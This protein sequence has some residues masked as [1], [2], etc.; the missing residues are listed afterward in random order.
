MKHPGQGI[1][2]RPAGL[3]G[4]LKWQDMES[5]AMAYQEGVQEMSNSEKVT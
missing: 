4:P 1:N 5:G 3:S 2:S